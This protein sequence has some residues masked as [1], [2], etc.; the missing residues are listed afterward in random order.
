MRSLISLV[1]FLAPC[2]PLLAAPRHASAIDIPS[3]PREAFKETRYTLVNMSGRSR[4][5]VTRNGLVELRPGHA[6]SVSVHEPGLLHIVSDTDS[7][8]NLFIDI[9]GAN[10]KNVISV[11]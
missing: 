4:Q 3:H 8:F 7:H 9:Q 2:V 10:P 11:N 1:L 5:L 6:M